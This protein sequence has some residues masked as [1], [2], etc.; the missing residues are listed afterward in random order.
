MGLVPR[1][2]G[3]NPRSFRYVYLIAWGF[4]GEPVAF[5]MAMLSA[6]RAKDVK[7]PNLV[8]KT[9]EEAEQE[10]KKANTNLFQKFVVTYIHM[11]LHVCC[12]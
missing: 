5:V 12:M 4:S 11:Y 7:L 3:T 1:I 6:G 10:L 8:R 2:S 9:I